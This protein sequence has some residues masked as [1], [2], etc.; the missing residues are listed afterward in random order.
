MSQVNN[1]KKVQKFSKA[2]AGTTSQFPATTKL[3]LLGTTYTPAQVASAFTA[4]VQG[5]DA[6]AT[7]RAQLKA[8]LTALQGT[9]ATANSLYKAL[10]QYVL[11]VFG[12]GSPVVAAFGFTVTTPK[13]RTAAEKAVAAGK[14]K[15]TRSAKGTVGAR[16]KALQTTSGQYGLQLLGPDGKP[17]QGVLPGPVA[18]LVKGGG[19]AGSTGTP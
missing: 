11:A 5:L 19:G 15:E 12:K 7:S 6:L 2:A 8:Q 4:V 3:D 18:P 17:I 1:T 13:K 10:E 16:E 9:E 14:A